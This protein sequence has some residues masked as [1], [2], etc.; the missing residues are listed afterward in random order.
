MGITEGG[1]GEGEREGLMGFDSFRGF[2]RGSLIK[3]EISF[4]FLFQVKVKVLV[5]IDG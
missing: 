1:R 2:G 4:L 3:R 5:V